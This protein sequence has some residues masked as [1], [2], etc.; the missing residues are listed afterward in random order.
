VIADGIDGLRGLTT[1]GDPDPESGDC[2]RL[3]FGDFLS[4]G[5]LLPLDPAFRLYVQDDFDLTLSTG[6]AGADST[7]GAC[8]GVHGVKGTS[9]FDTQSE[10]VDMRVWAPLG[11]VY[12]HRPLPREGGGT[13]S[14]G[15][16]QGLICGLCTHIV[17]SHRG[18]GCRLLWYVSLSLHLNIKWVFDLLRFGGL[19]SRCRLRAGRVRQPAGLGFRV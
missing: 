8:G 18:G 19:G 6:D 9:R 7:G 11:S 4:S 14:F 15:T 5:L 1:C 16:I 10:R 13:G 2:N 3:P 12:S 17:H